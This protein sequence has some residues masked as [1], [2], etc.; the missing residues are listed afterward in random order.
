MNRFSFC[1]LCLLLSGV[2]AG[3]TGSPLDAAS[4]EKLK[5]EAFENSQAG[6]YSKC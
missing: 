4:V 3:Q 1:S 2:A 5:R 6:R